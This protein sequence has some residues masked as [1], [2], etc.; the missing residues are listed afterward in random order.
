MF[1]KTHSGFIVFHPSA[2]R[3]CHEV[4]RSTQP[5]TLGS[6]LQAPPEA[7]VPEV[8]RTE[9]RLRRCSK[10]SNRFQTKLKQRDAAR[11][12]TTHFNNSEE[13][14]WILSMLL[15]VTLLSVAISAFAESVAPPMWIFGSLV[16]VWLLALWCLL[17]LTYKHHDV[18]MSLCDNLMM[19]RL[20][21]RAPLCRFRGD[22]LPRV[23]KAGMEM[24]ETG[25]QHKPKNPKSNHLVLRCFKDHLESDLICCTWP[26]A[27][28]KFVEFLNID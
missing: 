8:A 26:L 27:L 20:R 7:S 6:R 1:C 4:D 21:S 11:F 9:E 14:S 5:R 13:F 19:S 2:P 3:L 15:S 18:I 24:Q 10:C 16:E 28:L 22:Q 12:W 25:I 17:L 23:S